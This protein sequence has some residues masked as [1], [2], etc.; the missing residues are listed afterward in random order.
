L[1][2]PPSYAVRTERLP[3]AAAL[4]FFFFCFR[5]APV[6]LPSEPDGTLSPVPGPDRSNLPNLVVAAQA[7]WFRLGDGPVV[8][9]ETR[10]ALRKLLLALAKAKVD[11]SAGGLTSNEAFAAG[12]PGER[13]HPNAAQVRVYTAIHAIRSF[14][15]RAIL[16]RRNGAYTLDANVTIAKNESQFPGALTAEESDV[17][18]AGTG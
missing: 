5:S 7:E 11:T 18:L 6:S 4:F 10:L 3:G 8:Q 2:P 1:S 9:L 15:L 13:A 12:W 14:G 17:T 16:V